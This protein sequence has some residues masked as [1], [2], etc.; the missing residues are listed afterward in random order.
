LKLI[1]D[2]AQSPTARINGRL[3]ISFADAG[4]YSLN[5]HK[6]IQSGEGGVAVTY[7]SLIRDR[8][9]ALRNHGE[10]A[11][12]EVALNN[13]T[14]IGHNWRLG[15]FEA[16]IASLQYKRVDRMI[17]SRRTVAKK[18]IEG[19]GSLEGLSIPKVDEN[20]THDYYILGMH[21]D[22]NIAGFARDHAVEALRAEGID[23]V[24]GEYCELQKLPAYAK[25]NT[26]ELP[27]TESLNR[28]KFLGLY[29]CGYQFDDLLLSEVILAFEKV[30]KYSYM[31]ENRDVKV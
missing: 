17:S 31:G 20:T 21:F 15:E 14:L 25:Y 10:V 16:L 9:Q 11:A 29:L 1:A 8:L 7:D 27:I 12:P 23:F 18:L 5:R 3:P 30:W 2:S 26:K 22:S 4:G 19:L 28:A 6:H 13:R 24:I